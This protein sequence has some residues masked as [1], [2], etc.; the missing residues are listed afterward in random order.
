ML[1]AKM[2][3]SA[4]EVNFAVQWKMKFSVCLHLTVLVSSLHRIPFCVHH[5]LQLIRAASFG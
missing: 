2:N 3:S 5:P 4:V 1:M